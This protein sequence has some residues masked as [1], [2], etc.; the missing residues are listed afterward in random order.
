MVS[1]PL[2][3][4][5]PKPPPTDC[6]L[7]ARYWRAMDEVIATGH[8]LGR[9]ARRLMGELGFAY[10]AAHRAQMTNEG[11]V[12]AFWQAAGEEATATP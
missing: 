8:A 4:V 3:Q 1:A 6:E 9:D 10:D 12:G 2:A 11:P 7:V 5:K